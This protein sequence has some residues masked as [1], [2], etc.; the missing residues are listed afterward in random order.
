MGQ[1]ISLISQAQL[2]CAQSNWVLAKRLFKSALL[3]ENQRIEALHGLGVVCLQEQHPLR[4]MVLLEHAQMLEGQKASSNPSLIEALIFALNTALSQAAQK[5]RWQRVIRLGQR[6]LEMKPLQPTTLNNL[7]L[8]ALRTNQLDQALNWSEQALELDPKNTD[9]LNNHAS[10]LQERGD[11]E[12]AKQLYL[13]VLEVKPQ[14]INA[15]SNLG[16]L[17]HQTGDLNQARALY[18][19]HLNCYPNDSRVWVNLAG[20]YLS[21]NHWKLG[22]EAYRRRLDN[23]EKI[24]NIPPGIEFWQKGSEPVRRLIVV[25]EQGLGDSFQFSRFLSALKRHVR[26]V[27]FCGPSKLHKLLQY[28]EL[29]ET[30]WDP[31]DPDFKWQNQ[32]LNSEDRWI[33]LMS[34]APLLQEKQAI[35]HY[36][37]PY[38]FAEPHSVQRWEQTLKRSNQ[39][40]LIAVHWQGNPEHE[41][42]LSRGRSIALQQLES[43]LDVEIPQW[44]SLQ[45]G[46]GSEQIDALQ[47]RHRFHPQ[48]SV[49]DDCWDY[50][51]TAAILMNCDLVITSDSGLAHLAAGL[52][53]PTCLLLMQIPEWR[54]GLK[55]S[56]TP[57]Y[58]S[59]RLFRQQKRNDWAG[60]IQQQVRPAL[61]QWLKQ[62]QSRQQG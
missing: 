59:M 8:A 11:L 26:E 53:R 14:H 3:E 38:L 54:W 42:T 32:Y 24:M 34:L 41:M 58:P 13:K 18:Q 62:R 12:S 5:Q 57:W 56:T 28:S 49:V 22:W 21:Q 30:C 29:I 61:K 17:K 60:L 43:L 27:V 20:V 19:A 44:L 48:Q 47:W 25:H 40:S 15:R 36:G 37:A 2:A 31:D 33:P 4:A 45:K 1:T 52:G 6:S 50:Q 46:P 16:C 51:E 9:I 55:G 23:P 7:A 39:D 10:I 35:D